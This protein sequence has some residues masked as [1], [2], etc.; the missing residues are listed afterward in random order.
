M[1]RLLALVA[2]AGMILGAA[3]L[4]GVIFDN[5]GERSTG[6]DPDRPVGEVLR[7]RCITELRE[8]CDTLA[9]RADGPG[10]STA[11]T[12]EDA[13]VTADR[14]S[15]LPASADPGFDVW[16][17]SAAWAGIVEDNRRFARVRGAVLDPPGE[18]LARSPVVLVL[19]R[20][21]AE[22]DWQDCT[23]PSATWSCI[24][25]R[26]GGQRFVGL[27]SSD[28]ETGLV[29]LAGAVAGRVGGSD[30]SATD[31]DEPEVSGWL[32]NLLAASRGQRGNSTPL[33]QAVSFPARFAAVGT[34]E[35][36][37]ARLQSARGDLGSYVPIYPEPV[38]TSDVA[39]VPAAGVDLDDARDRLGGAEQIAAA[40]A[41]HGWRVAGRELPEGADPALDLP[42]GANLPEAGVLQNLRGR[43]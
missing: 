37:V 6:T 13:G 23:D 2:A 27:S 36:E 10:E 5:G 22:G 17:S 18:V 33:D 21:L 42:A 35:A 15:E 32:A 26:V 16:V 25:E 1:K 3:L 8:V 24:G 31:V 12:V 19:Q 39:L 34:L 41:G 28:S 30:Y 38:V 11:V 14:L 4:H 29:T 7:L 20:Q 40:L 9:E 43:W